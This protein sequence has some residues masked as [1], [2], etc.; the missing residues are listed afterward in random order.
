MKSLQ[1]DPT[2]MGFTHLATDGVLRAF[3]GD[4]N[5]V[6]YRKLSPEE[7][8]LVLEIYPPAY[9]AQLNDKFSGVD[10]RN[11]TDTQQ[12]LHPDASLMPPER[13]SEGQNVSPA[14]DA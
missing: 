1:K 13:G 10:G 11:V 12:C 8:E 7:I 14:D 3:D 5:V 6:D 2:G 4:R 9:R